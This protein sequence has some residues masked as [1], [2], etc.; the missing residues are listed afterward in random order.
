MGLQAAQMCGREATNDLWQHAQNGLW[1][2]PRGQA[3]RR[4]SACFTVADWQ[5]NT[6]CV[7]DAPL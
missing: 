6:S 4:C 2:L 5:T 7:T 1:L 3:E